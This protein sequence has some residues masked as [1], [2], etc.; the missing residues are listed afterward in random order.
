MKKFLLSVFV[1]S[2]VASSWAADPTLT[3]EAGKPIGKVGPL[4]SGLMTEEINY[5][6]DGGLY[7]ELIRNRAFLDDAQKP[8]HWS[9]VP[10]TGASAKIALDPKQPLNDAI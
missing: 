9:I 10:G 4:H 3:I 6:Y 5:C 7:A 2:T 8:V 1:I